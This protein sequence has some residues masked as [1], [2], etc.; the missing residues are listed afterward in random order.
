V[1]IIL[2]NPFVETVWK[3]HTR[4]QDFSNNFINIVY[5]SRLLVT[6]KR[7][8]KRSEKQSESNEICKVK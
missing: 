7:S 3:Q 5:K 6:R 8:E 4:H 1:N 2:Y